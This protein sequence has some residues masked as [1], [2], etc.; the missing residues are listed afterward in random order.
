MKSLGRNII[1]GTQIAMQ[2]R[3]AD[4]RPLGIDPTWSHTIAQPAL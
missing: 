1:Q 3:G 2:L 4:M